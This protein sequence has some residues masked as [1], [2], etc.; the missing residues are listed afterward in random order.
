MALSLK[1]EFDGCLS[2][3][4]K[5]A[6]NSAAAV[7][8]NYG[9]KIYL[10][11]GVVRDLIMHSS[12]KDIDIAVEGNAVDFCRL[13]EQNLCCKISALQENLLTA[14]V[15]FDNNIEIDFASTR[16]EKY[17][18]SGYLPE[19]YNF[20][21]SL[22]KDVKRRDFT[23]NTLAINLTGDDKFLLIDYYN[24][25][26]D[27]QNKLVRILHE[28]SFIDDP[29]RIIRALKFKL[30]FNFEF[31]DKTYTLMQQYLSKPDKSIPMERIKN[32]LYQYFSIPKKDI[33]NNLLK[34]GIYKLI[35]DK[36]YNQFDENRLDEIQKYNII[37]NISFFYT[38][39]LIIN[40]EEI[41][42]NLTA[43][44]MKIIKEIKDL[45]NSKCNNK[46]FEIY[47]KYADKEKL[48][49]AVYYIMTND[50]TLILFLE[51]LRY[52]KILIN[53][54]DLINIGL[55]PSPKFSKIFDEVLKEKLENHIKTKE[56][57]IN[58]VK[59]LIK[60]GE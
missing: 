47:K 1:K 24:G 10:I 37:D 55:N 40:D 16:E 32:E 45:L 60:K 38:S 15:L 44:E 29:S 41:F 43:K 31:E 46:K 6:I 18:K 53:G 50:K 4:F 17:L 33:Y 8:E 13:L 19:A 39:L 57:E 49:L 2:E 51:K 23:I 34:Y 5:T 21:C 30:R 3:D 42:I 27:I 14:K 28:K 48:A 12:V 35:S 9:I 20:G 26:S 58:F 59:Q 56:E 36:P 25:Y 7:A 11:G 54:K 52:T 22:E